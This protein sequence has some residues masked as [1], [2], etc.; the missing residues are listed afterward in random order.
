MTVNATALRNR[1][2][3]R[4]RLRNILV[5]VKTAE[6]G[7]TR[8]GA[9]SAGMTQPSASQSLAELEAL[10][11]TPL[12][13]RH[14]RGMS[15]TPAGQA[16]LPLA[17]RLLDVVDEGAH[18]VAALQ[19]SASG[20]VRIAAIAAAV[21]GFLMEALPR[22]SRDHSEIVLH[23]EEMEGKRQIALIAD[24]EIDICLCR[25]PGTLP[26]GWGFEPLLSDRFTIVCHPRHPLSSGVLVPLE[27][28]AA[29]TWLTV[30]VSMAARHALDRLFESAPS[31]PMLHSV[32]TTIPSLITEMLRSERL[33]ALMP[34]RL[35]QRE[36]ASGQLAELPLPM[37]L[38][39][40]D[41]GMLLPQSE[42][43][44]PLQKLAAFLH[45]FAAGAR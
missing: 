28:L 41:I 27:Q 4:A 11:Q 5:F 45:G 40:L 30:P 37:D 39:L 38:P 7:T 24:G 6:L 31:F 14:S 22:F 35:V 3:S 1:L 42:L 2:I 43:D 19:G 9:E 21:Q 33:L 8:L 18:R 13:F 29:E 25:H 34:R 23:L 36:V 16:L 44:R 15:L 32:V 10:L 12:F 26:E 17:R 20:V